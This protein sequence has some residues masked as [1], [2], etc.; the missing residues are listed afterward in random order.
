VMGNI[1]SQEEAQGDA[2]GHTWCNTMKT[3][4]ALLVV[5]CALLVMVVLI[6]MHKKKKLTILAWLRV[7]VLGRPDFTSR[8]VQLQQA[9][10]SQ[11][12]P[13]R[14]AMA[15]TRAPNPTPDEYDAP[16]PAFPIVDIQNILPLEGGWEQPGAHGSVR[17]GIWLDWNQR[18]RK[19]AIKV[20]RL[21]S[22]DDCVDAITKEF[23][24]LATL[25]PH[26]RIVWVI[27][28][29]L[30]EGPM[31]VQELMAM[32]LGG[33]LSV[34]APGLTYLQIL[35]IGLDVSRGMSHL[36]EHGVTHFGIKPSNILLDTEGRAKL[37]DFTCSKLK[38][39]STVCVA[40]CGTLGY[41]APECLVGPSRT[42]QSLQEA[43]PETSPEPRGPVGEVPEEK[44]DIYSF[45]KV[46]LECVTG[47]LDVKNEAAAKLCPGEVWELIGWCV[48]RD[49]KDRPSSEEVVGKL[50][51]M[52]Q[53]GGEWLGRSPRQDVWLAT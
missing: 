14:A 48:S 21:P 36:H 32:N 8:S 33:A 2:E 28:M 51:G 30:G 5:T 46:M 43:A 35:G 10:S 27:G 29:R 24:I 12:P 41:I 17:E 38:M 15:K 3:L 40:G 31:I 11:L 53:C 7:H 22:S 16:N 26:P 49:P 50:E 23:E 6:S 34:E 52:L 4:T 44:V 39:A 1:T 25:P 37:A 9:P 45:G 13:S 42:S 18:A 19:V 47:R 20:A